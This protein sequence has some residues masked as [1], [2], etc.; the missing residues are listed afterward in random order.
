MKYRFR[1]TQRFL[2]S[3]YALAKPEGFH[4]PRLENL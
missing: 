1:P 2:E 4:A 3:F